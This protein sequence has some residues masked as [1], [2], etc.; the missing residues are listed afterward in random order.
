MNEILLCGN[1]ITGT[2]GLFIYVV[3][4]CHCSDYAVY[5]EP[6]IISR[7]GS[8]TWSETNFVPTGHHHSIPLPLVCT[9]PSTST[10]FSMHSGS[11]VL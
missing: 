11:Y 5:K 9:V 3:I 8:V 1:K 6:F 7:T 10:I 2:C 4:Y